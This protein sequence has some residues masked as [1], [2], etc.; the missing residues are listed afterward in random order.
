MRLTKK[1]AKE[2]NTYDLGL[3]KMIKYFFGAPPFE[4]M[5]FQS[6]GR[7]NYFFLVRIRQNKLPNN[8]LACNEVEQ[9]DSPKNRLSYLPQ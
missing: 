9:R 2:Y 3:I 8:L 6:D 4:E 7:P 1:G 5:V